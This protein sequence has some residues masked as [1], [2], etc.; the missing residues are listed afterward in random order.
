MRSVKL[1]KKCKRS[2]CLSFLKA[3]CNRDFLLGGGAGGRRE[4][5]APLW[6]EWSPATDQFLSIGGSVILS[7][8]CPF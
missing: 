7:G 1:T 4:I 8:A 5:E 6:S 3:F 2:Q